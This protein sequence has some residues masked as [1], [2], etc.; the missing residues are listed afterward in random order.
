MTGGVG[1]EVH[2]ADLRIESFAQGKL[3]EEFLQVAR[4]V[5]RVVGV[6]GK[7]CLISLLPDQ[8]GGEDG[9]DGKNRT[10][11]GRKDKGELDGDHK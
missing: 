10:F 2:A 1:D 4:E 8:A 11:D 5:V 6:G 7:Q 3:A 9:G